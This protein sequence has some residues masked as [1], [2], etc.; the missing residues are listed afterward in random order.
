VDKYL[1]NTAME[2]G[3]KKVKRGRS[4]SYVNQG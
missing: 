1:G 4:V 3:L 2:L